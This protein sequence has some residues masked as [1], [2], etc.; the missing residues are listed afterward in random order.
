MKHEEKIFEILRKCAETPQEKLAVEEMIQKV[1]G[2]LPQVE[3]IDETH[4]KFNGI[5]YNQSNAPRMKG[6]YFKLLSLHRMVWT[7]Y[8]GEIPDGYDIHH[9]DF[10]KNNNDISNLE[11]LPKAVHMSL[12]ARENG[13]KTH[14]NRGKFICVNCGEE[15][16]ADNNGHN[17]YCSK[18]CLE[19]YKKNVLYAETRTCVNCGK[20]FSAYRY[21]HQKFCCHECSVEYVKQNSG[22][23]KRNCQVCGK[24]I[25][26][27][28]HESKRHLYCSVEC[29]RQGSS[30]RIIKICK[31]CGREY[32]VKL[33]KGTRSKYCSRKCFNESKKKKINSE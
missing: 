16:E 12:H 9:K 20:N 25:I 33:S 8:N 21:G 19:E 11:A 1:V 6:R 32:S 10:D 31:I 13:S 7:C 23:E 14:K 22:S 28:R 2:N 27:T 3:I 30:R 29:Q 15:Y 24:E 26:V 5:T 17:L 18:K 4:Q